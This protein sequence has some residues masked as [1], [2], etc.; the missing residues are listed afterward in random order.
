[1]T[2]LF[3][4]IIYLLRQFL[5]GQISTGSLLQTMPRKINVRTLTR[6]RTNTGTNTFTH[7]TLHYITTARLKSLLISTESS[8]LRKCPNGETLH[9]PWRSYH[10]NAF[11]SPA[12][13]IRRYNVHGLDHIQIL[14]QKQNQKQ[15]RKK[16]RRGIGR[17][18][19]G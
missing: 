17:R 7:S 10:A 9:T 19:S 15:K 3:I 18:K 8:C 4:F 6:L 16:K 1:M 14:A 13:L 11:D 5:S 12:N 2:N